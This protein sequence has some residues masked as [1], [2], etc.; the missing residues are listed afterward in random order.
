MVFVVNVATPYPFVV[1]DTV[2]IVEVPGEPPSET[3][4]PD[5]AFPKASSAVT[6]IVDVVEPSAATEVGE[7]DTVDCAADTAATL[8]LKLELVAPVR[9]VAAAVSV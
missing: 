5:T 3:D 7:A 1:P 8:M 2:V 6:V 4:W 9:P